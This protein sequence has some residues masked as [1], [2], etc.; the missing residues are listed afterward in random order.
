MNTDDMGREYDER[1]WGNY[2]VIDDAAVD[3]KV[4][5]I[6]VKVGGR[7]SLQSHEKRAEHWFV[8]SGEASVQLD[9]RHYVLT[10][11]QSV[12]IPTGTK[13]RVTNT[14]TSELVFI[15]VQWGTYFGEDDIVRYEDDYGRVDA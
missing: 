8:V 4:K 7:L 14:G 1:P 15:E 10:P 9:D 5:R 12:D 2:T 11:G 13:H 3:H 6:C